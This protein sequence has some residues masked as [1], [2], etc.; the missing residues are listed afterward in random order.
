MNE[1]AWFW[2]EAL[3][4]LKAQDGPYLKTASGTI[5]AHG[6]TVH[7]STAP[8]TPEEFRVFLDGQ[9]VFEL[10]QTTP[11]LPWY[12]LC[13]ELGYH[14]EEHWDLD[15]ALILFHQALP[16]LTRDWQEPGLP[17]NDLGV[18]EGVVCLA[19]VRS[20]WAN[21]TR[22]LKE[23]PDGDP[24]QAGA[25]QVAACF[26]ALPLR[27]VVFHDDPARRKDHVGTLVD[28]PLLGIFLQFGNTR[29]NRVTLAK[30]TLNASGGQKWSPWEPGGA[31]REEGRD[32]VAT[33]GPAAFLKAAELQGPV[34]PEE[35]FQAV[36]EG[37]AEVLDPL[38]EAYRLS[39]PAGIRWHREARSR[40]LNQRI[41]EVRMAGDRPVL[42]LEDGTEVVV[43]ET[44][45]AGLI[46]VAGEE[47]R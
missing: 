46:Q 26:K 15:P 38:V 7:R 31:W 18:P 6:L 1:Q 29:P 3:N 22:A 20:A 23:N 5:G 19:T 33:Q 36:L 2:P 14:A 35:V 25:N 10:G 13:Q 37:L 8:E 44:R 27:A 45:N 9:M 32:F 12:H 41:T 34:P 21:A 24:G 11:A 40:F 30:A 39:Y 47:D 17:Y 42:I 16:V 4:V 43:A 28:A